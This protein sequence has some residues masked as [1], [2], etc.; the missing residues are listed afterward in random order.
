M[1]TI[2]ALFSGLLV[3][4]GSDGA[5]FAAMSGTPLSDNV[6][7]ADV[8]GGEKSNPH[9]QTEIGN[10]DFRVALRRALDSAGFLERARNE[11]RFS[12]KVVLESSDQNAP[13]SGQGTTT[14][15]RYT[16]IDKGTGKELY[17][18]SIASRH[19]MDAWDSIMRPR[20]LRRE[21]EEAARANSRRLAERL[22]QLSLP[23]KAVS[24]S[25]GE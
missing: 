19:A 8:S 1:S 21:G 12:L 9:W 23:Q 5:S 6:G 10:E 3:L 18:E 4:L 22:S 16:L 20:K 2:W 7:I 13:D 11:G 24:L 17:E 14:R 15:V 25:P